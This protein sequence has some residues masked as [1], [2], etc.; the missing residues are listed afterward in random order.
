M[1]RIVRSIGFVLAVAVAGLGTNTLALLSDQT[2]ATASS[3]FTPLPPGWE[4]CILQGVGAPA[5]AS[6]VA[7]LDQ[8]QAAEGGSTNNTAAYNPYNTLRTTDNTGAAIAG[9]ATSA[10]GFP[11]FPSWAAGC[12]AT[13][14]T[15]FQPNMWVITAA[16]RAG[17][18]SPPAAFLAVVDQSSWCA[19]SPDGTPCYVNAM[20]ASPGSLALDVPASSA[21]NV[22]GNVNTD[23]T[24]YQQSISTVASD[25]TSVNLRSLALAAAETQVAAAHAKLGSTSDALQ[26]FAVSE[27][28]NSGLYSGAPLVSSGDSEPLTPNTPKSADGVVAQQYLGIAANHL[29]DDNQSAA[30]GLRS[31]QKLRSDAAKALAQASLRLTADITA[32]NHDLAQLIEDVGTLEHA[33]ACAAVTIIP[34]AQNPAAAGDSSTTTPTTTTTTPSPTTTTTVAPTTTTTAPTTTTTV[35]VPTGLPLTALSPTTTTTTTTVPSTTTTTVAPTTTTT[36]PPAAAPTTATTPPAE[37]S[38]VSQLQGCIAGFAPAAS[39]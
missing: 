23:L 37:A 2:A 38:G 16:L 25:Q 8:W 36:A 6:N 22:Y 33:G 35:T 39:T 31:S 20:E 26:K 27:Y 21:L 12:A 15:L 19:P 13:V 3:A 4:L 10:N 9:A 30:G 5:T 24:S 7:D 28:V 17:T 14:A 32:E 11:A 18:I 1:T 34:P 29:I